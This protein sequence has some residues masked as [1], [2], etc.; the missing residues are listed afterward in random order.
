MII[1][2]NHSCSEYKEA[3]YK[4]KN[5]LFSGQLDVGS[6]NN[7]K[8]GTWKDRDDPSGQYDE[9]TIEGFAQGFSHSGFEGTDMCQNP[10]AAQA[11]IIG[12]TD[13]S[14]T[15]NVH[16]GLSG[17]SCANGFN[18]QQDMSGPGCSDYEVRF[19]CVQEGKYRKTN[20]F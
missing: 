11:R 17:L 20:Y 16:F 6:C 15:E 19:C 4:I 5:L 18:R 12:S 7:G 1:Q 10:I 3:T 8:W 14:T 2:T 9:E 13:F